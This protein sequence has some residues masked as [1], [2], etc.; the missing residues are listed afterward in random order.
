MMS[1]LRYFRISFCKKC[2]SRQVVNLI[3]L[4]PINYFE[5]EKQLIYSSVTRTCVY[6]GLKD[7][8]ECCPQLN[9]DLNIPFTLTSNNMCYEYIDICRQYTVIC[10]PLILDPARCLLFS[11]HDI[12]PAS[13]L[14]IERRYLDI[15]ASQNADAFSG[16][17]LWGQI[18]PFL[19]NRHS[20]D[21]NYITCIWV[22][23]NC[24]NRIW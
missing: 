19:S 20:P 12:R 10:T 16:Y 17:Q 11:H 3:F 4:F 24:D 23:M 18:Y 9:S 22:G 1:I 5:V 21:L 6:S 2:Q 8:S 7:H 15:R 14:V 13:P